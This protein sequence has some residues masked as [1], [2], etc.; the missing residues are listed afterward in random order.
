MKT[1]FVLAVLVCVGLT[2]SAQKND[3][4]CDACVGLANVV[5]EYVRKDIPLS[6]VEE[7]VKE[8]CKILPGDLEDLCEEK[9][10]PE[11]DNIYNQLNS[12][13]P[14]EICEFLEFCEQQ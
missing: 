13:T 9:L 10:L 5:Q 4:L 8:L 7:E 2:V 14:Q 12:T 1:S 3:F 6:E 11:V